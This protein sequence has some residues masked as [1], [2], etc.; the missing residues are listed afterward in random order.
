NQTTN[1]WSQNTVF[2]GVGR[3]NAIGLSV[4][5]LGYA[6]LGTG[7]SGDMMDF[8][9]WDESSGAWIQRA[10]F[11]IAGRHGSVSFS[12]GTKGY[13]SVG[14]NNSNHLCSDLWEYN[15]S[16]N[17]WT[18]QASYP[19]NA[20][21]FAIGFAIGSYGYVGLGHDSTSVFPG[22]LW[23]WDPSSNT[24]S[25]ESNLSGTTRQQAVEFSIG[26]K[27]YM[28]TGND[29]NNS[30]NDFWEF[31]PNGSG[32][33][34]IENQ[35]S[36][37]VFPN[38]CR[39]RFTIMC[40]DLKA[41]NNWIEIYSLQGEKIYSAAQTFLLSSVDISLPSVLGQGVYFIHLTSGNQTATE[42]IIIP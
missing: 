9:Q 21:E 36:F 27:G 33:N 31:D 22:D 39:D 38:P 20:R 40:P 15:P 28:G 13:I 3:K 2:A 1:M 30:F 11:P 14:R 42:K 4:G 16:S 17:S 29:G 26:T 24:W 25:Q 18:Q 35:I 41:A 10:N 7:I 34:E 19:A 6:G 8:W 32:V 23:K 5:N 12:I 37:S